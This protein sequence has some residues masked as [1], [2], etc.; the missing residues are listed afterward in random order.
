MDVP[1]PVVRHLSA[2]SHVGCVSNPGKDQQSSMQVKLG[3]DSPIRVDVTRREHPVQVSGNRHR[4][5]PFERL[6]G[7]RPSREF[8][9]VW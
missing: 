9:P 3:E 5:T 4:R 6:H 2:W 1:V 8:V 7:K